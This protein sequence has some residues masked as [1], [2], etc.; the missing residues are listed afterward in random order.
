MT[1]VDYDHDIRE[2]AENIWET[3]FSEP[4]AVDA[5]DS[6]IAD[7]AVTG[8]VLIDGA[9]N[10]AVLLQVELPLA[11]LLAGQLFQGDPSTED[12]RDTVGELANMFAGNI[13]ALLAEPSSI[14]VPTVAFGNDYQLTVLRTTPAATVGFRCADARMLV[15]LLRRSDEGPS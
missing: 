2:I 3:L 6:A 13:K 1:A 12:V 4:L 5:D 10:G 8:A 14:S 7:P 11:R 9:W 15:A